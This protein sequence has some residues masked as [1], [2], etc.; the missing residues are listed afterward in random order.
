M[1]PRVP[2]GCCGMSCTPSMSTAS[3]AVVK[4]RLKSGVVEGLHTC[5]LTHVRYADT[6]R[7]VV[8]TCHHPQHA[9]PASLSNTTPCSKLEP[10]S[11]ALYYTSRTRLL[12]PHE[13]P[14]PPPHLRCPCT[15]HSSRHQARPQGQTAG[16][17]LGG[18]PPRWCSAWGRP[19]GSRQGRT[20]APCGSPAPTPAGGPRGGRWTRQGMG[21][22]KFEYACQAG[23]LGMHT[24]DA[25]IT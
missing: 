6:I 12:L 14:A 24:Q 16:P 9:L 13:A 10:Y 22:Y 3:R 8:S 19:R 20:T 18:R 15:P 11:T 5:M 7:K 21:T 1:L 25:R 17:P 23:Y 4:S 2:S